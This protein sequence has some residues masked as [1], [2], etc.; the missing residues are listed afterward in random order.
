MAAEF[1]D[2]GVAVNA[3][4]PKTAIFTA[5]MDM[6]AGSEVQ[7]SCRTVDIVADAAHVILS[8]PSRSFTGKF[9]VDEEVLRSA[10]VTDFDVYSAVPG[11]T[12]LMPDFFLDPETSTDG[13]SLESPSSSSS[14]SPSAPTSTSTASSTSSSLPPT[15]LDKKVEQVIAAAKKG[16][17]EAML[18]EVRG[19]FILELKGG[20]IN[21]RQYYL[22]LKTPPGGAGKGRGPSAPA[23]PVTLTCTVS[24]FL[25]LFSGDLS[26]TRAFM[27]GRLKISGS[28]G[29]AQRLIKF[30]PQLR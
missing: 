6:L 15:E 4:W 16:I 13:V 8:Q 22:D 7:K 5:A 27:T 21:E 28:M 25:M 1:Q 29:K 30:L 9:T 3:L 2:Q 11:S 23:D 26:P 10:G 20:E 12:E 17:N 18:A 14:T 19:Y 24:D